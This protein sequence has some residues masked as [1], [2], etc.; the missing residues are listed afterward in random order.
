MCWI[1]YKNATQKDNMKNLLLIAFFS[2]FFAFGQNGFTIT[3]DVPGLEENSLVYLAGNSETDTLATAIVKQGN[4]VLKGM[5][6]DADGKMLLFPGTDKRV[7]LFIGNEQVKLTASTAAL[8]DL[9]VTGSSTHAD[10]ET[11]IFEIKP[12]GDF[13]NYYRTQMQQSPSKG[14]RDSAAIMLNTAYNIY[15]TAIDRFI[16]RRKN[17]PVAALLLAYSYDMDPNKDISLLE[18]RVNSLDGQALQT[19]YALGI[20]QQIDIGKFGAVGTKAM[21]FSQ[22][23]SN[24]KNI[25]LSQFK[26]KYVLI[27]FWASWCKPCRME[28]PNVVAAYNRFKDKNFTVLGVSLDQ[29]KGNW[30]NAVKVDQLAWTQVSDLQYWSNA[31]AQLYRVQ[32]IPQNFLI[33]PNG[34]IIAKNLRGEDLIAKLQELLK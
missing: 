21:E 17:S 7:F 20:K 15:Q 19:R 22:A 25:S 27:D 14:A 6:N 18:K 16:Q 28:N 2:P 12:L 9:T 1:F 26:G 24:G 29:D 32:S 34:I 23:D 8:T 4:F 10:Y 31:V 30:L 3:G 13:V 33:D 11:F 5:L